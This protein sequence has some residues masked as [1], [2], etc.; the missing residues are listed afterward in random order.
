MQYDGCTNFEAFAM[1]FLTYA[2]MQAFWD[3]RSLKA[4]GKTKSSYSVTSEW[5]ADGQYFMTATT[6][7]RMQLD[8]R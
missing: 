1:S 4:L 6:A 8:N 3:R 2:T 5:S 7:P